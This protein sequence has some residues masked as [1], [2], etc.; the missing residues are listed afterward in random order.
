[1]CKDVHKNRRY[2]LLLTFNPTNGMIQTQ[3]LKIQSYGASCI[4]TTA[5][6]SIVHI[7]VQLRLRLYR[8]TEWCVNV[9]QVST[10][11]LGPLL[12][13]A[14]NETETVKGNQNMKQ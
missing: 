14:V 3:S 7:C 11:T 6:S 8:L 1:M 10:S 2:F 5:I 4:L 9:I 12:G 13:I